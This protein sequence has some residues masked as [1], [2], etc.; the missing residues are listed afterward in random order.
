ALIFDI[1]KRAG[2][3]RFPEIAEAATPARIGYLAA[4]DRAGAAEWVNEQ[5]RSWLVDSAEMPNVPQLAL[6]LTPSDDRADCAIDAVSRGA[7]RYQLSLMAYGGWVRDLSAQAVSRIL[8]CFV[9][10]AGV[11]LEHALEI[12]AGWLEAHPE[13]ESGPFE[14]A[15]LALVDSSIES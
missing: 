8:G 14:A 11:E 15:A 7:D 3:E 2:P 13:V 10:A 12:A 4:C 6:A 9:D 1:G 5:L